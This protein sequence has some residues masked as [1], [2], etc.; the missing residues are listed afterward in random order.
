MNH[1]PKGADVIAANPGPA[2]HMAL[3]GI[4]IVI[5]L[6]VFAIV[7]IRHRREAAQ[8]DKLDQTA[9]GNEQRG[10]DHHDRPDAGHQHR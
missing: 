6:I 3:L 9:A 8:A 10:H 4:V 1:T 7:R 2:T 5:G